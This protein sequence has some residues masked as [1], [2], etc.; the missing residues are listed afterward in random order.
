MDPWLR[1]GFVSKCFKIDAKPLKTAPSR[2]RYTI[3]TKN[4][5]NVKGYSRK[6]KIRSKV[7]Q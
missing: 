3:Y 7:T 6:K 2:E 5:K 4:M 1:V